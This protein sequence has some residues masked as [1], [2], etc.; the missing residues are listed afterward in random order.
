MITATHIGGLGNRLR[1]LMASMV[2]DP[3]YRILWPEKMFGKGMSCSFNDLW[4]NDIAVETPIGRVYDSWW[5]LQLPGDIPNRPVISALNFISYL[6]PDGK[7]HNRFDSGIRK[8]IVPKEIIAAYVKAVQSL[9]PIDY[10][11]GEIKKFTQK[12]ADNTISVGMRTFSEFDEGGARRPEDD[13]LNRNRE[14]KKQGGLD[15]YWE[16]MDKFKNS[17]FFVSADN[18]IAIEKAVERYGAKIIYRK[19][20]TSFKDRLKKVALQDQVIDL[21]LL[22]KN[23]III[24]DPLSSFTDTAWWLGGGEGRLLSVNLHHRTHS[25]LR[26]HINYY[27]RRRLWKK[28][29]GYLPHKLKFF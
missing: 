27:Y 2:L 9:E 20:R 3:D 17:I 15:L 5:L 7:K 1:C 24:Q 18:D 16:Q 26:A 13:N 8:K 14:F 25:M 12:F 22:S 23:K 28:I 4:N 19:R 29:K 21:Y 6:G 10:I 11:Q